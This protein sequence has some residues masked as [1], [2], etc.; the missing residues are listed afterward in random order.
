MSMQFKSINEMFADRVSRFS[1]SVAFSNKVDGNWIPVTWKEYG[2]RVRGVAVSLLELGLGKGD[3]ICILA[4]TR[5]E[6]DIC[7]KAVFAIGGITVGVYPTLPPD[8]IAHILSH[9]EGKALIAENKE[10]YD[11]YMQIADQCPALEHLILIDPTGCKGEDIHE[12]S[13]LFDP[14]QE[15]VEK[16]NSELDR[17]SSSVGP[18]DPATYIYT[19]GT[20]GPPKGVILTHGNLLFEAQQVAEIFNVTSDD[21]TL[22]WLPFSHVFQ[23]VC[24]LAGNLGGARSDYAESIEKMI[25]NLAECRPT[26]FYSVPRI[27]EKAYSKIT[28]RAENGSPLK[29]RIFFRSMELGHRVS[30]FRQQGKPIPFWLNLRYTIARKLVFDKIR[31]VFGGRIRFCA[32]GAAPISLEILEFFHA[33]DIMTYEG[34]G[35]TETTMGITFNTPNSYKFGTVGKPIAG[36]E[37]KIAKDGEILVRGPSIFSG[38]FKEAELTQEV[39]S[40]D[41]WYS[42][43]D[44]GVFDEDGFLKITDRKKDIIVTSAGK[45]IAPQNIEKALKD[46]AFISQ[47]MVYGDKRNYLTCLFTLDPEALTPWA[48]KMNLATDDWASLC[49]NEE[50]V[51]LITKEIKTVNDALARYETIKYFKIVP[52]EFSVETGELTPTLKVKR[53]VVTEKYG[54]I[55]DSMYQP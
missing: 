4:G 43:G 25:E 39:L 37:V 38:Y 42:T 23:R 33:A 52:D 12:L 40:P 16:H 53:K 46:V 48:K 28:E 15:L 36:S 54:D 19:S 35:A 50:V 21:V 31:Q 13:K 1:E 2:R 55:L 5:P 3:R 24:T 44:I 22:T 30:K 7:D 29:K 41:G 45:N 8:Q 9:S 20:T 27:F 32:S 11:K 49:A 17:L 10:Q 34:Y 51:E 26:I 18:G 14:S 47:A 6:W